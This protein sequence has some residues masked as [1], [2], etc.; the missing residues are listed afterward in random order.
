MKRNDLDWS[1]I[2]SDLCKKKKKKNQ[3]NIFAYFDQSEEVL[4]L[5]DMCSWGI[6]TSPG[7][8]LDHFLQRRHSKVCQPLLKLGLCTVRITRLKAQNTE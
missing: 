7:C 5:T 2:V 1:G 8:I 3:C 6:L 4:R